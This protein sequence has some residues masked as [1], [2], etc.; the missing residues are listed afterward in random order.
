MSLENISAALIP[1]Y[2][3]CNGIGIICSVNTDTVYGFTHNA[4][5]ASTFSI[6]TDVAYRFSLNTVTGGAYA[7]NPYS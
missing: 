2:D 7:V 3:R 5:P 1:A 6:N 4:V